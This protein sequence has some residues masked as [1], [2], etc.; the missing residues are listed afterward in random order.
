MFRKMMIA[1]A[2]V[3]AVTAVS[4][5]ASAQRALQTQNSTGYDQSSYQD[6][7]EWRRDGWRDSNAYWPGRVAGDIVGGAIGTA[8]A[9]ATA[10]FAAMDGAYD[11]GWDMRSYA[12]R[13]GFVCVPG[14]MFRGNDGLM[15]PCQ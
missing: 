2:A 12:A 6:Q 10:P 15:H 9:I 13:N 14:T 4:A 11:G 1:A 7:R 3:V 8:G 5:P